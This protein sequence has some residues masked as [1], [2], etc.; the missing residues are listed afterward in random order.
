MEHKLI[1]GGAQ[2]LPFARSRL[3]TLRAT[4]MRYAS[5]RFV[6]PDGEVN[7]QVCADQDY[8]RLTG[9]TFNI[10]SGV[11][12]DG[13]IIAGDTDTL[14]DYKPTFQAWKFPLKKRAG[15]STT[16]FH[17][18][19][20][21]AIEAHADLDATGSQYTDIAAS[22]YSGLMAKAAQLILGYGKYTAPD[23]VQLRYNFRFEE[24][25]GI[26]VGADGK[27]W[28]VEISQARGVLAT[29]LT[30][31]KGST[32]YKGSTQDVLSQAIDL[33][34]GLPTGDPFP[35]G[36]TLTE[37]LAAGT[38][39]ELA[40][41][42][43]LDP[44][45]T[46]TA[47][48]PLLGWSF[49]DDGTEARNTCYSTSGPAVQSHLYQLEIEI[50]AVDANWVIGMPLASGSATLNSMESGPLTRRTAVGPIPAEDIPFSFTIALDGEMARVPAQAVTSDT[51]SVAPLLVCFVEG[52]WDIVRAHV[53]ATDSSGIVS[54][55]NADERAAMGI[56]FPYEPSV[57]YSSQST[58]T[59][60][61]KG[62]YVSST[63]FPDEG[64]TYY[65]L[66]G[67]V[68]CVE[69]PAHP[70]DT[71]RMFDG[72]Y[73]PWC[74]RV[75][76]LHLIERAAT[77][78]GWPLG[79]RDAYVLVRGESVDR[80]SWTPVAQY[81]QTTSGAVIRGYGSYPSWPNQMTTG[82]DLIVEEAIDAFERVVTARQTI[83][84]VLTDTSQITVWRTPAAMWNYSG[85]GPS[86]TGGRFKV[87]YS[88]FGDDLH[89]IRNWNIA[90]DFAP[91]VVCY[92]T[93][94]ADQPVPSL[95]KFSFIGYL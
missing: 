82:G 16:A 11:V 65:Y 60:S 49:N 73:F 87:R 38:V 77:F 63:K 19:P 21:L 9:N 57:G 42:S 76:Y 3:K 56:A 22:M 15:T 89:A 52:Q 32:A 31:I 25:H 44:F 33:F 2:Y 64:P 18:E 83:G 37:G 13:E 27:L 61:Y 10:L 43:D 24:C 41:A 1:L 55:N 58:Q 54:E 47:F 80:E 78:G 93:L 34:D 95:H 94:L 23:G 84:T 36:A 12:R 4:G 39:I 70:F 91:G 88:T 46:K 59:E 50:G 45:Y 29:R 20:K 28:I 90:Q 51:D 71:S 6:L 75:G 5:Q 26:T 14:R 85:T 67:E 17:D 30:T 48:S 40:S 7:V 8:I 35:S 81:E 86:Y 66:Y 74:L 62:R 79:A 69:D 53:K 68:N 72:T 92:G